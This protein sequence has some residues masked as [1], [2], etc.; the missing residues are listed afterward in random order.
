MSTSISR[1]PF[2]KLGVRPTA[3]STRFARASRRTG[4]PFQAIAAT[5]FQNAGCV[6]NPT[7]SV[8]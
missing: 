1:G 6:A 2:R 3:R 8:R 5:R 7:G 4:P